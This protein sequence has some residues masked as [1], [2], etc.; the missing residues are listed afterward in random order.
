MPVLLEEREIVIEFSDLD[1]LLPK[2]RQS[3]MVRSSG[4]HLSGIIKYILQTGGLLQA[5]EFGADMPLAMCVGMAW[6]AF[7][8]QLWPDFI[9]QPG[10]VTRDGIIGS[11][12]G[13]TGDCLEE[14]KATW[15]SR[16]EKSETKGVTPPPR[17]ITDMKRW[18]LQLAGYCYMMGLTRARMHVLWVMGDYRGSGP[19]YFTYLLEFTRQELERTWRNMI[20]KN[21]EGAIP[22]KH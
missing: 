14:V 22:E 18:M 9:W 5:D 2:E 4:V 11:P 19:Q 6:E 7:I 21:I 1:R 20:L 10:E 15:M 16:L 17:K 12:D 3:T 13:I 8:V